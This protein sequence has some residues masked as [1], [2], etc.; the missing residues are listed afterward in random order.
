MD[1]E[2][3]HSNMMSERYL[4]N[5]TRSLKVFPV[6]TIRNIVFADRRS[7]L[8]HDKG[9]PVLN[10][11]TPFSVAQN[12]PHWAIPSQ[13]NVVRQGFDFEANMLRDQ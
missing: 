9:H 10:Q 3:D 13:E 8:I 7:H 2:C 1:D 11:V 12:Q 4:N 6:K 5:F